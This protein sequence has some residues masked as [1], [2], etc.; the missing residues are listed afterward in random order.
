MTNN[1][2]TNACNMALTHSFVFDLPTDA[3]IYKPG[4]RTIDENNLNELLN[5][6]PKD[7]VRTY[8]R[9]RLPKPN[10]ERYAIRY[11]EDKPLPQFLQ[12]MIVTL[13]L[14]DEPDPQIRYNVCLAY[15]RMHKYSYNTVIRYMNL[16]LKHKIFSTNNDVNQE[17]RKLSPD[18]LAFKHNIHN[19]MVD[20]NLYQKFINYMKNNFNKFTAPLLFAVLTGLRTTEILQLTTHHLKQLHDKRQVIDLKRKNT[21]NGFHKKR[22][23][24]FEKDD[25]DDDEEESLILWK[26]IYSDTFVQ[27]IENIIQLYKDEYSVYEKDGISIQLFLLT[28]SGL[29]YRMQSIYFKATNHRLPFGFGIHGNRTVLASLMYS[30]SNN[31]V[32]TS[33][34]LQHKSLETTKKYIRADV[35]NLRKCFNQTMFNKNLLK[36]TNGY[37]NNLTKIIGILENDNNSDDDDDNDK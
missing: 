6:L 14:D 19:R 18:P 21:T 12:N 31:L 26:P 33:N 13:R 20:R 35:I 32:S 29:V 27:F 2:K 24:N 9:K 11:Y 37:S 16:M 8:F 30:N 15:C 36:S 10:T 34:F 17:L 5:L 3:T 23:G 4:L 28:P 7:A 22:N 1:N 25:D